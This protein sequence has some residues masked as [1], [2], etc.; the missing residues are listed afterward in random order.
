M[1]NILTQLISLI[2]DL[3]FARPMRPETHDRVVFM[4][5]LWIMF[6]FELIVVILI[7]Q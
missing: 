6:I 4:L 5:T 1:S 3:I 7:T 2:K